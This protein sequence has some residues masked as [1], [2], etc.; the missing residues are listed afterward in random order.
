MIN[1][2]TLAIIAGSLGSGI[3]EIPKSIVVSIVE[4]I[5]PITESKIATIKEL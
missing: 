2:S 1:V 5:I 4:E 3:D